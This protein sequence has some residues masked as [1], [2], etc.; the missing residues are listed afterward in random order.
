MRD[1]V[2]LAVLPVLLYAMLQRPFI[3]LAMWPWTALFFPNGWVYGIAGSIRYNLLFAGIT[4]FTYLIQK[5]KPK[6]HFGAVGVMVLLFFVWTTVSTTMAMSR[7]DIAWEIWSRFAK[8]IALFV[9]IV[10]IVEKKLHVDAILWGVV[11]SVGF[12]GNL[13]ALKF[14]ASGGGHM[15]A[16][17][18]GHVLG[19]RNELAVA[20]VMTL[21]ICVYL[22]GEYGKR[23]RVISLGLIGTMCLLVTAV[24]GTQSRGGFIAVLALGGYLFLKSDRKILLGLLAVALA[25][26]LSHIVS[27]EWTSRINTINDAGEDAS[28]MGRVVAWKLSF[29]MAS[30]NPFF[31]GGFKSLEYLPNWLELSKDFFSYSWFYTGDSLPPTQFARAAHSVYFQVLGEHGFFG[32]G[33]YLFCL[34]GAYRKA[35]KVARAARLRGGPAWLRSLASMLQLSIFAFALGGAALSFAYFDLIFT[36][37]GLTIVLEARIMPAVL[38]A[39]APAAPV[40]KLAGVPV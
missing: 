9:F 36:L 3:A 15:I 16:G 2:L 35:G 18:D 26:G 11:L 37:F 24:I 33:I 25:I 5:N 6:V 12:Y 13:E 28:F 4:I 1:L 31:G 32:L 34:A 10:L 21:P 17:M 23:S 39:A 29:I 38:G 14:I 20:F 27:S 30:Q 8:V 40:P 19:D 7:P 22:L